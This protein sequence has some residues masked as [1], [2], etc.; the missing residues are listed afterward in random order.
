MTSCANCK[1]EAIYTYKVSSSY[2]IHYCQYHLP[3]F[4]ANQKSSG[5]LTLDVDLPVE[6]PVAPKSKKKTA[7]VEEDLAPVEPV[8]PTNG[9]DS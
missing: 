6:Q 3:K 8:A 7:T 9:S 5:Q 1:A 4:L 2:K